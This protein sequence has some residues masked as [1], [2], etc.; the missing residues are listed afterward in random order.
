MNLNRSTL[1]RAPGWLRAALLLVL[2]G[3][4]GG[5]VDSGGTGGAAVYAS[6]PINGFGSIIVNGVRFDDS[7]Q[8]IADDEGTPRTRSELKL[9]MV[10]EVRGS[11]IATDALTGI[12]S[13]AA[14]SITLGSEI[15]GPIAAGFN[16]AVA[17][18]VV[19]GRTIDVQP[20][21]V[22]ADVGG[23]AALAAGNVVEVYGLYNAASDRFTATRIELKSAN[24]SPY[25][26]RG[27]IS[28]LDSMAK[29]FL[30][31]SELID[32]STLG[33][34][35]PA[36][37]I[38]AVVRVRFGAPQING[39]WTATRL[40]DGANRP[41]DGSHSKLEGVISGYSAAGFSI[42]GVPVTTGASVIEP[43]GSQLADGI[44]VE[45]EGTFASGVLAA[46]RIEVEASSGKPEFEFHGT[47]EVITLSTVT[48]HGGIS[49]SYDGN[50]ILKDFPAGGLVPG[51]NVEIKARLVNGT[52]LLAT[53][54][55]YLP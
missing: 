4:C 9:G 53:R 41:D 13:S 47:V 5:G 26:I 23:M 2:L 22:F 36:L 46:S 30:I 50:T 15:V 10:V 48:I 7:T 21:T 49:I 3:G 6:G 8:N 42:G 1:P 19:L 33:S 44:R 39:V 51:S 38:G 18:F 34:G 28:G 24:L 32:Y 12:S 20:T 29:K 37:T 31:G 55:E 14:S 16:P 43:V 17:S 25:R 52:Q 54:I 35:V 11:A 45:V 27:P 40:R